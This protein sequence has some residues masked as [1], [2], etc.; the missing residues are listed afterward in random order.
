MDEDFAIPAPFLTS[1][2]AYRSGIPG[3]LSKHAAHGGPVPSL[4]RILLLDEALQ[5]GAPF[6]PCAAGGDRRIV[7][8]SRISPSQLRS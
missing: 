1:M 3:I 8:W 6:R 7:Q 2:L 5:P 4:R